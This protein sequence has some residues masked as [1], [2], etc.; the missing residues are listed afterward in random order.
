MI[1][2]GMAIIALIAWAIALSV[3]WLERWMCP[4]KRELL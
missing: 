2:G 4:W 1:V 3:E